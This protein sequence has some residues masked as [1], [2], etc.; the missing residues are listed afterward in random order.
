[1][2]GK[3]VSHLKIKPFIWLRF[4]RINLYRL[5]N[6]NHLK[7]FIKKIEDCK[8]VVVGMIYFGVVFIRQNAI[9]GG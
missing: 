8:S 9:G 5:R 6:Q 7:S 1:M 3:S 4:M 2:G